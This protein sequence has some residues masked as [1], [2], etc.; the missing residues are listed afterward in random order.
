MNAAQQ[1]ALAAALADAIEK[2]GIVIERPV[3]SRGNMKAWERIDAGA[4]AARTLGVWLQ[5]GWS[6]SA[7][8]LGVPGLPPDVPAPIDPA[9]KH[10]RLVADNE[11]LNN[12]DEDDGA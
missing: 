4:A 1:M 3:V 8:R 10:L 7:I 5:W 2:A 9:Q 6:A 12:D 11:Q